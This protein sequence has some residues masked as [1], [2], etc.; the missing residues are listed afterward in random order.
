MFL[1]FL[2]DIKKGSV[3]P[4]GDLCPYAHNVFEY[5]LHPT[6]YRTQLCNDGPGCARSFCFFAHSLDQLRNPA[7]KPHVSPE[8]LA[9]AS[10]ASMQQHPHPLMGAQTLFATAAKGSAADLGIHKGAAGA[11]MAPSPRSPYLPRTSTNSP[12]FAGHPSSN[13]S[14]VIHS[15]HPVPLPFEAAPRFATNAGSSTGSFYGA[16][17]TK[18]DGFDG[19][20]STEPASEAELVQS[21]TSLKIARTQQKSADSADSNHAVVISALQHVL[22]RSWIQDFIH[23]PMHFSESAA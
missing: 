11:I 22:Q 7:I 17:S 3:C 18:G 15:S 19:S 20:P 10:L 6:R 4:R 16:V 1:N 8:S 5:W 2:T 21:L 23:G 12:D 9:R 13:G 14:P